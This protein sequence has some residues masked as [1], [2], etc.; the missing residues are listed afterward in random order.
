MSSRALPNFGLDRFSGLYLGVLFIIVFSISMP[1]L[2]FTTATMHTIASQQAITAMLAL[3]VIIPL[4]AGVF[5]LSI[6]ATITIS[7]VTVT[8]LQSSNGFGMW[9]SIFIALAMGCVIG[10]ANGFFVVKLGISSFIA[11]LATGTILVAVQQ[12]ITDNSQPLPPTSSA[13]LSLTQTKVFGFQIIVVYL[14]ILAVIIWWVLAHTPVGRYI[15]ASG[16]N[17]EAARLTGVRVG[18]WVWLSFIAAGTLSALAGVF[19]ASLIGASLTF[20]NAMLLP[21]YAAAFLGSTQVKPGRFNVWGTII[22]VYVLAI[23]VQG[24][25]FW[26]NVQWLNEMF[27][28]VA[29]LVAV[30]FATW[31]QNRVSTGRRILRSKVA[32]TEDGAAP[33]APEVVE[34]AEAK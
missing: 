20:G 15:Y 9:T 24:I 27:N 13:W 4:A 8:Q 5:D 32:K 10:I 23:G 22:A 21:A 1:N 31:R 14:F 25:Q 19:Y 3:A 29:L 6:G 33:T 26:T 30:A 16:G 17:P 12:I 7:A 2:F 18:R 11:T 34:V 28:G